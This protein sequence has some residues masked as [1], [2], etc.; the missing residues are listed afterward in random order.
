MPAEKVAVITGAAGALGRAAVAAF[1][2]AGFALALVDANPAA[3]KSFTATSR[4]LLLPANLLDMEQVRAAAQ[5]TLAAYGRID[6]LCNIAGGFYYGEPVHET[7]EDVWLQQ[8]HINATTVVNAS[9]AIVPHMV[10]QRRGCVINIGGG[11]HTQGHAHMSAY[12]VAKSAVMRLTESM[13]E[14]LRDS[15]VSVLCL[16]PF[17]IDTPKNRQDMPDADRSQ[18]TPPGAV[19]DLMV[20]LS[21]PEASLMSGSAIALGG[22]AATQG[23]VEG[24]DV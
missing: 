9:K 8:F 17:T 14:E 21:S 4:K 10:A 18:W 13:A 7:R 5:A 20:L 3:L 15:G 22:R 12:A 16:M 11:A 2:H 23:R 6:V 19:A 1:E 24:T